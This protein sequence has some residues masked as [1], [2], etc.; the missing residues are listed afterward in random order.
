VPEDDGELEGPDQRTELEAVDSAWLS[1]L[2]LSVDELR[3]A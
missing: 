1:I 2:R 3:I